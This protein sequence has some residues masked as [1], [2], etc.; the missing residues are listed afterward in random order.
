MVKKARFEAEKGAIL[1][2]WRE[3]PPEE[4]AGENL[5]IFAFRMVN[6]HFAGLGG[7]DHYQTVAAW[8]RSATRR[9]PGRPD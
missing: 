2:R 4:Q 8:L 9:W 6:E 3:L 7:G 1:A 5:T